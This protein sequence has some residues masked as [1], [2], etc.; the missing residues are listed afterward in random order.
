MSEIKSIAVSRKFGKAIRAALT[1]KGHIDDARM[2]WNLH[3][4]EFGDESLGIA[5]EDCDKLK[6]QIQEL[7]KLAKE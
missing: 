5:E 3:S 2:Y 4:T 6:L 1:V 7:R